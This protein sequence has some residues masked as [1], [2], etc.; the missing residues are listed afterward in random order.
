MYL[1][2]EIDALIAQLKTNQFFENIKIVKA[3]PYI[4][5]PTRLSKTVI[6]VSPSKISAE[7]ISIGSESL[8]GDYSV[9]FDI[10]IPIQEGTPVDT[11][12]IEQLLCTL[13]SCYLKAAAVSEITADNTISCCTAKCTLTFSGEIFTEGESKQL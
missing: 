2:E 3:F 8:F 9:D 1:T 11:A 4:N 13:S 10:F 12:V 5:K 7:N 6:A